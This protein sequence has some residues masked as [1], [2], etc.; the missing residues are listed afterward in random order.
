M[1]G[2][3]SQHRWRWLVR[4]HRS[5]WRSAAVE[6]LAV[7]ATTALAGIACCGPVVMQWLGLLIW[8]IG[9]RVLLVN[10]ARYELPV[11]AIV[12]LAAALGWRLARQRPIRWANALLAGVATVLAALRLTWDIR[13][14]LIAH[15]APISWAF[16]FRQ[17]VLLAAAGITLTTRVAVLIGASLRRTGRDP[18]HS[19]S[20]RMA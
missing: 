7:V 6:T 5:P 8:T 11:L 3:I 18:A 4:P 13:P 14:A 10:L 20:T 19:C 17:T 15:V 12:S 16:T 9:G 2:Q 1:N